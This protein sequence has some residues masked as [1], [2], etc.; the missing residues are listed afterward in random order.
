MGPT[1]IGLCILCN[2]EFLICSNTAGFSLQPVTEAVALCVSYWHEGCHWR[3]TDANSITIWWPGTRLSWYSSCRVGQQHLRSNVIVNSTSSPCFILFP[4]SDPMLFPSCVTFLEVVSVN[5]RRYILSFIYQYIFIC[6]ESWGGKS[7][8]LRAVVRGW[9]PYVDR[10]L[11]LNQWVWCW[12][13][14]WERL[15]V[16]RPNW[17]HLTL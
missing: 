14:C 12:F 15:I 1:N 6:L 8:G 11:V 2:H 13:S 10:S 7:I 4:Q 5:S 3:Y 9:S 16:G 17:S